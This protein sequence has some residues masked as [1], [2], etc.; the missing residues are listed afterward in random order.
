MT[1]HSPRH[2][3]DCSY[4]KFNWCCGPLCACVLKKTHPPPPPQRVAEVAALRKFAGYEPAGLE[5]LKENWSEEAQSSYGS[6][7]FAKAGEKN[8]NRDT[9]KE[10]AS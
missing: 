3:F 8:D 9:E 4:C 2:A 6:L 7:S 1:E 5:L 10:V